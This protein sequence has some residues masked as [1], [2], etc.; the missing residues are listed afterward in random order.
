MVT[1]LDRFLANA[2]TGSR[3]QVRKA[4]LSGEVTVNGQIIKQINYPVNAADDKVTFE[5]ELVFPYHNVYIMFHKPAQSICGR[6]TEGGK[7]PVFEWIEHPYREDLSIAGRLDSDATGLLLLS[8]DGEW[9]HR[10][11]SPSS[12]IHK[13]YQVVVDGYDDTWETQFFKGIQLSDGFRC[14][15]VVEFTCVE[16]REQNIS[17]IQMGII[18]GKH[19]QIKRMFRMVGSRV[20]SIHRTQI[21][22]ISLDPSLQPGSWKELTESEQ[23]S[24]RALF[25]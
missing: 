10:I 6:R 25:R 1:R 9:I 7:P 19:H 15:P 18:E 14:K 3:S 22:P 17:M 12:S 5:G 24:I 2:K 4:I 20:R 11:I 13:T 8:N 16:N 21:G 23:I